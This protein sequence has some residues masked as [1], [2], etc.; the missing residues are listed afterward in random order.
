MFK[1]PKEQVNK[2]WN[3]NLQKYNKQLK[4]IIKTIHNMKILFQTVIAFLKKSQT[5]I[6]VEIKNS[7]RQIISSM[8]TL[9]N[10]EIQLKREYKVLKKREKIGSLCGRKCEI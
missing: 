7:G 6:K 8:V 4:E 5:E 3:K 9:S 2:W 1:E 10:R